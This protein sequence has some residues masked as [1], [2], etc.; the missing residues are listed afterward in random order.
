MNKTGK[1]T[2]GA[3]VAKVPAARQYRFPDLIGSSRQAGLLVAPRTT[4]DYIVCGAG[5]SGCVVAMRLAANLKTQVLLLEACQ[6]NAP[7]SMR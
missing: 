5:T 3:G 4:F 6:R 1:D 2:A 7:R